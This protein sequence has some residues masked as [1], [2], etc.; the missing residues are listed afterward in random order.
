[1]NAINLKNDL[2]K[3]LGSTTLIDIF[4]KAVRSLKKNTK[5]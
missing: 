2:Q 5:K 1:M 4:L 3:M